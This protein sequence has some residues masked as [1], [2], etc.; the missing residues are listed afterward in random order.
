MNELKIT[1]GRIYSNNSVSV[2]HD[3]ETNKIH[4]VLLNPYANILNFVDDVNNI[5]LQIRQSLQPV[6]PSVVQNVT[7]PL[8]IRP[9]QVT[10]GTYVQPAQPVITANDDKQVIQLNGKSYLKIGNQIFEINSPQ[11]V[12]EQNEYLGQQMNFNSNPQPANITMNT[13]DSQVSVFHQKAAPQDFAPR[14]GI[15][16]QA[17][18]D[19]IKL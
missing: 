13:P 12:E 7:Q 17:I 6:V 11:K 9:Q 14:T 16:K 15:H 3:L 8:Y 1:S 18:L 2:I 5:C 19:G 10:Q 4:V